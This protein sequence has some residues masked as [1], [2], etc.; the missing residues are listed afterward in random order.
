M[1]EGRTTPEQLWG[2][3]KLPLL[4]TPLTCIHADN[5]KAAYSGHETLADKSCRVSL[6]SG[7]Y[8]PS[9]S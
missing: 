3:P 6:A 7:I 2:F 9:I 4:L 8:N 5:E 1:G